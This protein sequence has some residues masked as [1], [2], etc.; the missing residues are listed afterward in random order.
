MMHVRITCFALLAAALAAPAAPAQ[1]VEPIRLT[2]H[3]AA[4]AAP[5]LRYHLLPQ[6]HEMRP[7]NAAEIYRQ[8]AAEMKKRN[9]ATGAAGDID[10]WLELP[11]EKL[12]RDKARKLLEGYRDV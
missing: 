3:P 9:D 4:P 6:L 8:A 5:A 10:D 11:P 7:G 12:P 2:L 1:D